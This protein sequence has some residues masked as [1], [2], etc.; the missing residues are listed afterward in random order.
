MTTPRPFRFGVQ[1]S[2][3][4]DGRAWVTLA[5]NVESL[6][7]S[8]LT[9]PDHFDDQLAPVPALMAAAAA[10]QT[11]R[12]GA[13]V[14]DNDY[15]HP[16]VLAK[17]LATIDMLSGGRLEIGLGAGWLAT[18]YEKS[19]IT[20]DSNKVRVDRFEEGLA[21]IK[22]AMSGEAF[23]FDGSHY[24]I[25]D[26]T[27]TPR[28]V[29]SPCPPILV[30]GGGKR[31]LSIAARA[32][33]IIGINGTLA[34]GVIGPEAIA[35]MTAAAV[36]QKVEIVHAAAGPR[37]A[38]LEFNIRAFLVRVTDDRDAAVEQIAEFVG[39]D[40]SMVVE[41]PFVLIG[42]PAQI[43]ED[44]LRRRERWGFTYVIVGADDVEPFAPVVKELA[45]H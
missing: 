33:D 35:T 38:H 42:T 3:A 29:Q 18:D 4:V 11:L 25:N 5:R 40:P 23:S 34:A 28:P 44:L 19:G 9:M 2:T 32:A 39:V 24:S 8:T 41:S 1:A 7:Y 27:G 17:E 22:A 31:V 14:W 20:Y 36:D 15:K 13:L 10:T 45:G 43:V 21:V 16:I 26:F 6:G 30:G 37:L 12:V